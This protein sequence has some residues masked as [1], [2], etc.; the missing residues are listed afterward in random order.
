MTQINLE[1]DEYHEKLEA[2]FC[3]QEQLFL[4]VFSKQ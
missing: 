3:H 4:R 2:Y 1:K